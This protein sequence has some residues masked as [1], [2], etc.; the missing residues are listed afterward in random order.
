MGDNEI[1]DSI[2]NPDA[3]KQVGDLTK[4]VVELN[5]QLKDTIKSA[6]ELNRV[7]GQSTSFA[8]FQKNAD[9]SAKATRAIVDDQAKIL[10]AEKRLALQRD[11][12]LRKQI[13][14]RQQQDSASKKAIDQANRESDVISRAEQRKQEAL[15]KS[16]RAFALLMLR[17]KEAIKN[18]EDIGAAQGSTSQAF[19]DATENANKL[20]RQVQAIQ[21]PLGNFRSN[22]GNYAND[23]TSVFGKA[24]GFIRTLAYILPGIGIAG[25]FSLIGEG[26]GILVS[27]LTEGKFSLD[28]FAKTASALSKAFDETNFKGAVSNVIDLKEQIK[29]AKDGLIDQDVVLKKYNETIG[30]TI[31]QTDSLDKAE[32]LIV[33]HSAAYIKSMFY[34]AA[35]TAAL[36]EGVDDYTKAM[37][38][39]MTDEANQMLTDKDIARLENTIKTSRNKDEI[40][41]AK[42]LL[43]LGQNAKKND[44]AD[45]AEAKKH[46]DALVNQTTV[47]YDKLTRLSKSFQMG[48]LSK[49]EQ[50]AQEARTKTALEYNKGLV[51]ADLDKNNAIAENDKKS[52]PARYAALK[53]ALADQLEIIQISQTEEL[54]KSDITKT[55]EQAITDKANFDKI[56]ATEDYQKRKR[57]LDDKG[58][59]QDIEHLKNQLQAQKDAA[60]LILDSPDSSVPQKETALDTGNSLGKSLIEAQYKAELNAAGNNDKSIKIAKDNRNKALIQLQIDYNLQYEKILNDEY[61]KEITGAKKHDTDLLDSLNSANAKQLSAITEAAEKQQAAIEQQY[62]AGKLSQRGYQKALLDSQ[63]KAIIDG[64]QAQLDYVNQLIELKSKAGFN[65]GEDE[66]K[67]ADIQKQIQKE[68]FKFQ[69]ENFKT[70]EEQ[71]K[72]LHDLELR[73][74]EEIAGAIKSLVDGAYQ[75]K[76]D[77]L[78]KQSEMITQNAAIEKAAIDR[79]LDTQSNKT[80]KQQL[81]DA[82]TSSQQKQLQAQIN[83]EKTA[84][85]KADKAFNIAQIIEN[86]AVAITKTIAQGGIFATPL[87]ALIAAIGAAQLVKVIATPI[88][89]FKHGGTTKGGAFIWGEAGIEQA[90]EP[91]GKTYFS[92]DKATLAIAPAGTKIIPHNELIRPKKMNGWVSSSTDNGVIDAINNNTRTMKRV[93]SEKKAPKVIVNLDSNWYAYEKRLSR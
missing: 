33:D 7:T 84:Q 26:I 61:N 74:A 12:D 11:A 80:R 32:Q 30:E 16:N 19:I 37:K 47:I 81:L 17:Y 15:A 67:A 27:K 55:E 29:L 10:A 6:L 66:Q 45:L 18:A 22:V 83:K 34:K 63:H 13:Q 39:T 8:G 53:K 52:Y 89:Q 54:N 77:A 78:Q 73:A 1:I 68:N 69:K 71:V 5:A 40:E 31:G 23:I 46:Q 38:A 91:S 79:S 93:F 25:I 86:T 87:I 90:I 88:P 76:I 21:Q 20:G 14:Q 57:D 48:F 41:Q 82:Q 51:Q 49:D 59:A 50:E 58:Y 75:E 43:R 85:A 24:F 60:K 72:E 92:P 28:E 36:A 3:N 70:R 65:T 62:E 4:N 64:Y 42:Y 56:K 35:A 9:A 44:D 2:V